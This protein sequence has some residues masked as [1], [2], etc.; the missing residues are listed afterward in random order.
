MFGSIVSDLDA[1]SRNR[2]HYAGV[3]FMALQSLAEFLSGFFSIFEHTY[4][5]KKRSISNILIQLSVL[6]KKIP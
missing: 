6:N 2:R 4:K 1:A 3:P 5:P